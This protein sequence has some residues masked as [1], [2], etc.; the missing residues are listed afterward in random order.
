VLAFSLAFAS[1][2]CFNEPRENRLSLPPLIRDS[3]SNK[4]PPRSY[5]WK[6]VAP[7]LTC[8][9]AY[10]THR[11]GWRMEQSAF[12][13]CIKSASRLAAIAQKRGKFPIENRKSARGARLPP[14]PVSS[15]SSSQ[16][17]LVRCRVHGS[18]DTYFAKGGMRLGKLF[19]SLTFR[20]QRPGGTEMRRLRFSR[21]A[22]TKI[23]F[24]Q[25]FRRCFE[26]VDSILQLIN[27]GYIGTK[28]F[29]IQGEA[30]CEAGTALLFFYL[31]FL[32]R[33]VSDDGQVITNNV[34]SEKVEA[35]SE[36]RVHRKQKQEDGQQGEGKRGKTEKRKC[37][38]CQQCSASRCNFPAI[39]KRLA[40]TLYKNR[41][42]TI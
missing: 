32:L 21:L 4:I 23:Y 2:R 5:L 37:Q 6:Q 12:R 35:L 14:P 18:M 19:A 30:S 10:F 33:G 1:G 20:K 8:S 3:V 24:R 13:T 42:L 11:D 41:H 29:R 16:W 7:H 22:E 15:S 36:S 40:R 34:T 31:L 27:H 39:M 9:L 28:A 17:I 25:L 26:P 38:Q